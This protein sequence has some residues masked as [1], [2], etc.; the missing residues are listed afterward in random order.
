MSQ[1]FV[2]F[3]NS[4]A[5]AKFTGEKWKKEQSSYSNM[6]SKKPKFNNLEIK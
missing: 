4:A 2:T 6:R 3:D 5:W 1:K